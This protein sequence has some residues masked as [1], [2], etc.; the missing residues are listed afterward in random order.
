MDIGEKASGGDGV[1]VQP[2]RFFSNIFAHVEPN[3]VGGFL[4][5]NSPVQPLLNS[6]TAIRVRAGMKKTLPLRVCM[7]G[8]LQTQLPHKHH[9]HCVPHLPLLRC[10]F[11]G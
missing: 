11:D 4:A 10:I 6:L 9:H 5:G 3:I 8:M 2:A 7:G 1:S